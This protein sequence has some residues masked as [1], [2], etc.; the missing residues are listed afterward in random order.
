LC[1][2]KTSTAKAH[3]LQIL[4][5]AFDEL[6]AGSLSAA[7]LLLRRHSRP[8]RGRVARTFAV[9]LAIA[10]VPLSCLDDRK[11]AD[12][13]DD[14]GFEFSAIGAFHVHFVAVEADGD[15]VAGGELAG[16]VVGEG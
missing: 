8:I 11:L 13:L 10:V 7:L 6:R 5:G 4:R 3:Y 9:A 14:C 15:R 2:A 1:C 16:G 12:L